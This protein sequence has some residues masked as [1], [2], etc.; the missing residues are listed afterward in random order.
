MGVDAPRRPALEA[1][2][3]TSHPALVIPEILGG[4][5]LFLLG[6]VLMTDGLKAVAGDALRGLLA[7]F[8]GGPLRA[9]FS[10]ALMTTL[11]QSSSA[12]TLATIGFVSAGLLT[13][14]QAIGVIFG[15]NLGTT[16][17]GWIVSLLGLKLKM[18]TVALPLI[19]VGALARLLGRGPVAASGMALAGFGLLFVGIDTLTAG[20]GQLAQRFDPAALGG[21]GIG[22]RLLLV[23]VGALMSVVMQS[24]SAAMVTTLAAVHSGSLRLDEAA[25]LVIGQNVGTTLTAAVAA[26]GASVPAR[27]TALAHILFNVL[28]GAVAFAILPLFLGIVSVVS[29][30]FDLGGGAASLAAF[31]TAFNLLGVALLLPFT[32]PFAAFIERVVP[33]RG[34]VLT[35]LLDRSV[36]SV[37]ALAVD[38]AR[39]TVADIA[40]VTLEALSATL[41]GGAV[42]RDALERVDAA[43][44]ETRRFLGAVHTSP[45]AAAEHER[46]VA[47]LHAI[48]HFDRLAEAARQAPAPAAL[49]T[50]PAR[51]W[52][53]RLAAAIDSERDR[54]HEAGAPPPAPGLEALSRVLAAER[55]RFRHDLLLRTAGGEITPEQAEDQLDAVRWIDRLGYHLWRGFHHLAGPRVAAVSE[56]GPQPQ[57]L[58]R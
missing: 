53:Q 50:E 40:A 52:A 42:D 48:D 14:P 15:A 21:G 51:E 3:P 43:I 44:T 28:T 35:R 11:V 45:D 54:K 4:I 2:A 17:T 46:H 7:R 25:A 41:R 5:G 55:A 10:G 38:T 26:F 9:L 20:M 32:G 23:G 8:T 56:A 22:G 6:M 24:S 31:H 36:A 12:T 49:V 27:R 37:P 39:R 18:G 1:R 16:S 47:L 19:G 34:P 57:P 33:E 58:A 30:R 29:E 13:F